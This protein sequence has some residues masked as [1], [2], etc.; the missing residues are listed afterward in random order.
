MKDIRS[1]Y[2]KEDKP[3][4]KKENL[5]TTCKEYQKNQWYPF[6]EKYW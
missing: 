4:E 2:G 1:K 3:C 6:Q 5:I